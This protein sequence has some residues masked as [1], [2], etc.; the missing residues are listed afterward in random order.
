MNDIKLA[1]KN[2]TDYLHAIKICVRLN[3]SKF[4]LRNIVL[5][6]D[7]ILHLDHER[8][9]VLRR[10]VHVVA[11]VTTESETL[12]SLWRFHDYLFSDHPALMY[13]FK[14]AIEWQIRKYVHLFV[15]LGRFG[16]GNRSSRICPEL[17][18][19]FWNVYDQLSDIRK[20]TSQKISRWQDET[21]SKIKR[22]AGHIDR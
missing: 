22:R 21:K 4:N 9:A 1:K 14:E 17:L 18:A 2:V 16:I 8:R 3:S 13:A 7:E 10:V 11:Q 12:I 20:R 5:V 19:D 6:R 15:R